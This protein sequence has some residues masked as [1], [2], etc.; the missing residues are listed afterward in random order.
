MGFFYII[1][2]IVLALLMQKVITTAKKDRMKAVLIIIATA[3]LPMACNASQFLAPRNPDIRIQMTAGTAILFPALLCLFSCV[4]DRDT[5]EI[6]VRIH[7]HLYRL[8]IVS[9]AFILYGSIYM[10][11]IDQGCMYEKMQQRHW[12]TQS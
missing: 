4:K 7:K 9:Y 3:I 1:F 6:S 10:I 12:L 8:C 2:L 11:A 5:G